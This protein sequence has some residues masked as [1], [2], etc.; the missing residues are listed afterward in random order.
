[1]KENIKEIF[2]KWANQEIESIVELPQSGS[3]RKY[4]RAK[5][6]YKQAL[7]VYNEDHKENVAFIEFSKHF[8]ENNIPVPQIFDVD[9]ENNIYLIE[10]FGDD[11]LYELIK[12]HNTSGFSP[13]IKEIYKDIL[14]ELPKIQITAGK[15]LDYSNAYPREAFDEQSIKWD[16]SYFKYYF[17][18]LAKIPFYEQELEN[19]FDTLKD[20][21]LDT[22][23]D[24]FL[25]R[26]FQSRNILIKDNKPY[27][28]DYQGGRKGA[29]QYDLASLLFD[30]KA[31]IPEEVRIELLE[32]YINE[33]QKYVKVD[34]DEF[35]RK[36]CA[37]VLVRILQAMGAYGFRGFFEQKEHFLLSIPPAVENLKY[38]LSKIGFADKIP[39]LYKVL[40]KLTKS[41]ELKKFTSKKIANNSLTVSIN[42]FS[43]KVEIP[44]DKEN[45]GGYI[46]DCR[47]IHNPGRYEQYKQLTG[48]DK[49]VIDFLDKEP[50]M[51]DFLKNALKL[52][53]SSVEKYQSRN[54]TNLMISFGC[55]GGQHRSVYSAEKL[56]KHL[57]E[58]YNVDIII[59]HIEQEKKNPNF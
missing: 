53:D 22:N 55:T 49:E 1:M 21:L 20:I 41:E 27:F 19:D 31:E 39:H 29:L 48:K 4:Y 10:D 40:T 28:I 43:F 7:V 2:R 24:Y 32:F 15:T 54:F 35:T 14:R 11:T 56:K 33:I 8:L 23:T 25:Y 58:K 45:G 42:S 57:L 50:E 6:K 13:F 17:L 44:T 46:F 30:A 38:I 26:D 36:F 16:L 52:V 59:H 51:E 47:A 12:K 9:L 3:Y 5:S 18:K 37:Y 34:V